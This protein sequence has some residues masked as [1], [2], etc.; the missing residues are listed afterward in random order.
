MLERVAGAFFTRV[1]PRLSLVSFIHIDWSVTLWF[2]FYDTQLKTV[3]QQID[4]TPGMRLVFS[5]KDR[6]R[7]HKRAGKIPN[8]LVNNSLNCKMN[9]QQI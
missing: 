6:T 8:D 1:F 7:R 4:S 3:L 2:G 9:K 5:V